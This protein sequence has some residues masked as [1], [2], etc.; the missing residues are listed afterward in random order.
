MGF[1]TELAKSLDKY[2]N[3][4]FRLYLAQI[5]DSRFVGEDGKEY[6]RFPVK[7]LMCPLA[8]HQ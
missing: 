1:F 6:C 7:E 5:E 2:D 8:Q 4:G 3:Y